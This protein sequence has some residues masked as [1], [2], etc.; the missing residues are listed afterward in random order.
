MKTLVLVT[1]KGGSGK[2]SLAA[3]LAVAAEEAGERVF[4]LDLDRQGTLAN[5][6]NRRTAET[7]GFDRVNTEG[8]LNTALATLADQKFTLTI[9]D[10][11]GTDN[12]LVTA[13]I[14]AADLCLVPTRPTPA[15]LEATQPTLEAI[16]STRRRFAF[17]LNQTP[18]RSSRLN[19]A[20]AGLRMF[21]VLAE[22]TISQRND[23][24]DAI[25]AGQGVTEYNP[26]G[27]AA[28]E[29]RSLWGWLNGKLKG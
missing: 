23:H 12:P 9:I 18:V 19:E 14:R 16:Q 28:D 27:K 5:W 6:I 10:T 26:H 22:P 2:S 17:V 11:P 29:L 8:E 4:M 3:S 25:G 21:G 24:Q 13:A 15:D 1:Q 20:A 7:P